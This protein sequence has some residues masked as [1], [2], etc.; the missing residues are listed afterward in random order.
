LK[1]VISRTQIS[2]GSRLTLEYEGTCDIY[3]LEELGEGL[4]TMKEIGAPQEDQQTQLT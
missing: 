2:E 4:K 3:I 1:L